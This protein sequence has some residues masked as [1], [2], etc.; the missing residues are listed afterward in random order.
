MTGLAHNLTVI[1]EPAQSTKSSTLSESLQIL[2]RA[3]NA[4]P[5]L[6]LRRGMCGGNADGGP[7]VGLVPG[8]KGRAR[9]RPPSPGT[10]SQRGLLAQPVDF[11]QAQILLRVC[12]VPQRHVQGG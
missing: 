1:Q 12:Q 7:H 2:R 11:C 5:H 9:I 8:H 3:T 4:Q 10:A 6:L